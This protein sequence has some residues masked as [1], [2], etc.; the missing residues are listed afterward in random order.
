MK[1]KLAP[2]DHT[3]GEIISKDEL[4]T[5]DWT[6]VRNEVWASSVLSQGAKLCYIAICSHIWKATTKV[7]WPGQERLAKMLGVTIRS[8]RNYLR[9]LESVGIIKTVRRGLGKTNGYLLC[10]Q[11]SKI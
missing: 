2:T 1:V 5:G 6:P 10:K 9:E 8:T 11:S 4:L 7:A 3:T